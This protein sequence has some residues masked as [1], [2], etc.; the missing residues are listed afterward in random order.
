[1]LERVGKKRAKTLTICPLFFIV[2]NV[3]G[4]AVM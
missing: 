4:N 3:N 2:S 1:M